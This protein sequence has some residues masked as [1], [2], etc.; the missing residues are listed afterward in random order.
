MLRDKCYKTFWLRNC[1]IERSK[2]V[3][4]RV[5][6]RASGCYDAQN[7]DIQHCG[8]QSNVAQHKDTKHNCCFDAVA[9]VFD[10]G[11]HLLLSLIF[12]G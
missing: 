3:R 1:R 2:L 4:L 11:I 6:C 8:T 10:S 5:M 12:D 9:S 7:N